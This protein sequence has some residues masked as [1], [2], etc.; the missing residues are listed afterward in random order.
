MKI[1]K[2]FLNSTLLFW[3][4]YSA[5]YYIGN[6]ITGDV[7]ADRSSN[8][9]HKIFK[10]VAVLFFVLSFMITYE[11]WCLLLF[12]IF[13]GIFLISALVLFYNGIFA[14][15]MLETLIVVISFS[16]LSYLGVIISQKFQQKIASVIILS[17][18]FVS[19]ISF[20]EFF[21]MWPVLGDYWRDTGGYRSVSTLLN[22]NNL[23][24][25]LGAAI[26]VLFLVENISKI[27][28]ILIF[29]IVFSSLLMTGSRTAWLSLFVA[30]SFAY[31]FNFGSSFSLKKTII[32]ISTG[33]LLSIIILNIILVGGVSLP[34][35]ATD[36]HTAELR[37]DKYLSYLLNFDK[38][39]LI[40]DFHGERI[41]KVSESS[42]F[43]YFNS[44]G[45]IAGALFLLMA[46]SLFYISLRSS[47][48]KI[49]L[50]PFALI[51]GYYMF[52]MIFENV[53]MSFPN[54][55]L[56]F[57]CVGFSFAS[58]LKFNEKNGE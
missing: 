27:K 24:L 45:I 14:I 6:F 30:G 35:R 46:L 18:L 31:L 40:P 37:I 36:M 57:L 2:N 28:K 48:E 58:I 49:Y 47:C 33:L 19:L 25:Y 52:A 50:S 29:G 3:L 5:F 8:I 16:G 20:Y 13:S 23:G 32:F 4:F 11:I 21:F 43:Y 51:V 55:Q 39:Y 9:Y 44:L 26:M 41:D 54:N 1:W 53:L 10:Y 12:F 56:F 22:P 15:E 42:Y 7:V 34:E 17:A 38:S